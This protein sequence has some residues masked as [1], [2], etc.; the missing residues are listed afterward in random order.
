MRVCE[1]VGYVNDKIVSSNA[2]NVQQLKSRN[3]EKVNTERYA[4]VLVAL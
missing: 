3:L 2:I 1:K 4:L